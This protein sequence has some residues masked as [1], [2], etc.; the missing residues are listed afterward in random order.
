MIKIYNDDVCEYVNENEKYL[1]DTL[2]ENDEAINNENIFKLA[3]SDIEK[4]FYDLMQAVN[5]YDNVFNDNKILC[6]ANLGL[7]YGHVKTQRYFKTLKEALY[8][9]DVNA[10]Y[11]ER[12]NSTLTLRACHHDGENIYKFYSVKNGKKYAINYDIFASCF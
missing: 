9:E 7:W 10:L 11:F 12:K 1:I 8:F 3:H 5:Y 2:K 6:V 4:L